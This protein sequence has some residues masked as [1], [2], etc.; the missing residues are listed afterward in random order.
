MMMQYYRF[1]LFFLDSNIPHH[2]RCSP[3]VAHWNDAPPLS[4][5]L[6]IEYL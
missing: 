4:P 6:E 2:H 3:A 1:M 5:S